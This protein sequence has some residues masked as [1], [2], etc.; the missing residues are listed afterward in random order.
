MDRQKY[1]YV[2]V[3]LCKYSVVRDCARARGWKLIKEKED[4]SSW[5]LWWQDVSVSTDRVTRMHPW[6]KVNHIP[7]MAVLHTKTGLARTLNRMCQVFS[8]GY[9]YFPRTFVLPDMWSAFAEQFTVPAGV[10]DTA[11][12]RKAKHVFIVKPAASC[13]GRGI[14]LT[15]TLSE[16]DQRVASIAQRYIPRPFLVDGLNFDLRL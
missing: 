13:Q 16:V 8:S 15:R 1:I 9:D 14:Y 11:G 10:S 7:G 12:I 3:S 2:N 5:D 4:E 6:Q